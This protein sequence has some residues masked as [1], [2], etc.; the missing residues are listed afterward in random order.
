MSL[1]SFG[2]FMLYDSRASQSIRHQIEEI[3]RQRLD[4]G[5]YT[6]TPIV[7]FGHVPGSVS[8]EPTMMVI[9]LYNRSLLLD[10]GYTGSDLAAPT[11]VVKKARRLGKAL[12]RQ[13]VRSLRTVSARSA[14]V[15]R[16]ALQ[17]YYTAHVLC[18]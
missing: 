5:D 14:S 10:V 15:T 11:Y 7:F 12:L 6:R 18:G 4:A 8:R 13:Y 16:P 3:H 9:D 17:P 1:V 2:L